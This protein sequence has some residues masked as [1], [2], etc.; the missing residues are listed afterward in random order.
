MTAG[1]SR[2][3]KDAEL[4][5]RRPSGYDAAPY[6]SWKSFVTTQFAMAGLP[7]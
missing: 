3:A 2:L 4:A 6:A 7:S 5:R 1:D